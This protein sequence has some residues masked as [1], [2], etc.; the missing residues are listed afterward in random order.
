MLHLH[1]NLSEA[2]NKLIE[3][4]YELKQKNTYFQKL[5]DQIFFFRLLPLQSFHKMR[6]SSG[7]KVEI[8]LY[9]QI[10]QIDGNL[11]RA[12]HD[13]LSSNS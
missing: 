1:F 4:N 8:E 6:N 13:E 9:S 5:L 7:T 11:H 2:S 10:L 12:R 3:N